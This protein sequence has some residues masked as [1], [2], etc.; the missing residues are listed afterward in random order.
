[1]VAVKRVLVD[2]FEMLMKQHAPGLA[3]AFCSCPAAY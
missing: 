3:A 1:L 2:D